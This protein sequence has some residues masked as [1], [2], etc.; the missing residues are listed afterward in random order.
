VAG[1]RTTRWVLGV[2][3]ALA[4]LS[5]LGQYPQSLAEGERGFVFETIEYFSYFTIVSNIVVAV[6][7]GLFA[8]DPARRERWAGALRMAGVVMITVTG[9]VYHVLL[10]ADNDPT[11]IGLVTDLGLHTVVPV[12]TVVGWVVVGPHRQFGAHTL[13]LAMMLPLAWLTYALVREA[14]VGEALYPFMSVA[15]NGGAQV[16]LTLGAITL[17]ALVLGAVVLAGDRWLPA[18]ATSSAAAAR[19]AAVSPAP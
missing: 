11:G 13:A 1:L 18:P 10:A 8:A 16:A 14:V 15:E 4:V 2:T 9:I 17:F 7:T 12:V 19:P 6:S 5:V 3:S